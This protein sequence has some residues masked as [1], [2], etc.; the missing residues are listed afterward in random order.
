MNVN[1]KDDIPYIMENKHVPNH[2]PEYMYISVVWYSLIFY[3][4]IWNHRN[5]GTVGGTPCPCGTPQLHPPCQA[6]EPHD[7]R[8][9]LVDEKLIKKHTL[10]RWTTLVLCN[11]AMVEN[12]RKP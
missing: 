12:H 2:Q 3:D 10:S 5:V 9:A 7:R 8:G 11:D 4:S 6:L 1:G